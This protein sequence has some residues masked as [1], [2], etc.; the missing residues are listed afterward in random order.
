LASGRFSP[1][2]RADYAKRAS[3]LLA[4]IP[5]KPGVRSRPSL[6]VAEP[7]LSLAL[8]GTTA[9][10]EAATALGD[11]PGTD[12][13]RALADVAFDPSKPAPVRLATLRQLARNIRRFG[14]R[15]ASSQERRLAGNSARR[16][17][18][19]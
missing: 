17:T 14:P 19:P 13:Q 15:L 4:Q 6:P 11:I 12:A 18:R 16:P 8:N 5:S 1:E 2:E 10:I 3:S 7:A 9:P